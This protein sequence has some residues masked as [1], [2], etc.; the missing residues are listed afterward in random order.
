MDMDGNEALTF[1]RTRKAFANGDLQRNRN[2][3]A[4]LKGVADKALSPSILLRYN[5]V[6]SAVQDCMETD[7]DLSSMAAL[8]KTVSGHKTYDGWNIVSFGVVGDSSRQ[9]VLWNG[10]ALS[11]VIKNPTSVN[12]GHT[13]LNKTLAGTDYKT[14]KRLAKRYS[15]SQG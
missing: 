12:R 9:R 2:Q 10:Q 14:L 6:V 11:V 13:L 1:A 3:T 7:I 4:V 5:G 15:K 8:Q